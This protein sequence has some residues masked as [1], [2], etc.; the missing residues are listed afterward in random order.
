LSSIQLT[1]PAEAKEAKN[2]IT[3]RQMKTKRFIRERERGLIWA[4]NWVE[5]GLF[6]IVL[7]FG[8]FG[9]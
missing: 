6:C 2:N 8:E 5:F 7:G 1:G 4:R 3:A 9:K